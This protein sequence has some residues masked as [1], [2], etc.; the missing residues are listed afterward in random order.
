[1]PLIF[2]LDLFRM[3]GF[4]VTVPLVMLEAMELKKGG[5]VRVLCRRQE[6]H[7][8][9]KEKIEENGKIAVQ[10]QFLKR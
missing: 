10:H 1:M 6:H 5:G 2:E 3:P 8:A 4:C 7:G 9:Q